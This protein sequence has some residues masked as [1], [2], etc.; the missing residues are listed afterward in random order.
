MTGDTAWPAFT[1]APGP[2]GAT[3]ATLAAMGRPILH[4]QDPAFRALYAE[5]VLGE[6]S[7]RGPIKPSECQP[8]SHPEGESAAAP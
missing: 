4:H 6:D 8:E 1:L 3:P 7:Y 2:S 5:T